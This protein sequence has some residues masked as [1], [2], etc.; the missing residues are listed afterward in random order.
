MNEIKQ[1][2]Q[3][4]HE[5]VVKNI[6]GSKMQIS[7]IA[8]SA[9]LSCSVK[10]SCSVSDIEEKLVNIYTED[11]KDYK[12]GERVNV[13]YAQSLGYRALFLGYLLPFLIMVFVLVVTLAI[14]GKEGLSGLLSV[15]ILIPYYLTLY[16]TRQ[17]QAKKFSFSV[18]KF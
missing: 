15:L 10:G 14:T 9:C 8:K 3:I 11:T 12:I 16:I 6:E 18:K 17:N 5:G 13:F 7:I 2:E 1:I 4:E